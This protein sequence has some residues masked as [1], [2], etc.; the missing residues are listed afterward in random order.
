MDRK[1][2]TYYSKNKKNYSKLSHSL[3]IWFLLLALLPLMTVSL[4]SYNQARTSLMKAASQELEA[5]SNLNVKYIKN[6]FDYRFMDLNSLA[7]T[8]DNANLLMQ[9]S[10]GFN[11]SGQSIAEYVKS[12]DWALIVD[13][14]DNKL[15]DFNRRYDYIYDI[16]LID[17]AGN[18]LF[19]VAH[20]SDFG[21]NLFTGPF[22]ETLFAKTV[23]KSLNTGRSLFSDIERYKPS[24]NTLAGFL[25]APLLD[26]QGET[27]GV[28]T[29]QIRLDKVLS[30][31]QQARSEQVQESLSHYLIGEDKKLRTPIRG[32]VEE[33]LNRVIDSE[34][35]EL[36]DLEHGKDGIEHDDQLESAFIYLGPDDSE[37]IGQHQILRLP[38]VNWA[39]ISEISKNEA[40][41]AAKWLANLTLLV[42][43]V[44]MFVVIILAVLIARRI[45]NPITSLADISMR[46]AEGETDQHVSITAGNEIGKL[47][48]AFNDMLV[49][50]KK[51]ESDLERMSSESSKALAE[52]AEQKFAL[53]QHSIVAITD[54]KGKITFVNSKFTEISG[55]SANELIGQNHRMLNSGRH[56]TD[57]FR[58][59]YQTIAAGKV[60]NSEI[61]NKSKSGDLYWVD[62]TIVPFMG[63]NRK[64]V[65]Y[66]AIRTDITE[67]KKAERELIEAKDQAEEA[68]KAKSEF[69]ASMSHEIRTPMNGVL[70]M[71][72]LLH[73]TELDEVQ[74]HRVQIAQ[75]SAQSLL[76]L[77]ND[78]LDFSK[79]EAGKL[80][81]ELLDF[82]L[83]GMLG[84]LAEAM[85]HQAQ[86]K[87]LELVLDVTGIDISMVVGDAGRLRQIL[88]NL[89]G[90]AIKFTE[91]GEIVIRAELL[92]HK[93]NQYKMN[94]S[95][96]DTGIGIPIEKQ[97]KLFKTFSQVDASTTRKYGGTGLGLTIAKRLCELMGGDIHVRSDAGKGSCFELDILLEKS[98]ESKTV[99][100]EKNLNDFKFLIVDGNASYRKVLCKQFQQWGADV[101]IA[102]NGMHAIEKCQALAEGVDGTYFDIV[103]IEMHMQDMDGIELGKLLREDARYNKTKLVMMTSMSIHGDT[104][105]LADFGF[106]AHFPKPATKSDLLNAL[107]VLN[108]DSNVVLNKEAD[109]MLSQGMFEETE[110]DNNAWTEDTRVLLVE[111]NEVNQLVA[112]ATLD[113]IG[114]TTVVANN[115]IEALEELKGTNSDKRFSLIFMDCQMPKMDG[116]EASRK[117]RAG[118]A[119]NENIP[120]PII[121]LT[122]NA[123]KEDKERCLAAGMDDYLSKPFEQE[124]IEQKLIEWLTLGS[125]D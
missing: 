70:G 19:S 3:V 34:Q 67:R 45:T 18:I 30:L 61:C 50:R 55:Y 43:V 119:G 113:S 89:V 44:T 17:K 46:V 72:A 49:A 57:F 104:H 29:I 56:D 87:G 118:E 77:I 115:G 32:N 38:G 103:F 71:L 59:M 40:L 85:G 26:E 52:L 97:Y 21:T 110:Q 81:L 84:E 2:L 64:P 117:I 98:T 60:W 80:D 120:I 94:C 73:N 20:E 96:S 123:M 39:L 122:A 14:K 65:S 36:L 8:D 58:D 31:F 99:E 53:D 69:L 116:F 105:R 9:L 86:K 90:N 37:V 102:D 82:D 108:D 83:L 66:V 5:L 15:A 13:D 25:S 112:M 101:D 93:N 124:Q 111:D 75:S 51:Y 10:T 125:D 62:T 92:H 35:V 107:K 7:E 68:V 1:K 74:K 42:V 114:V 11:K 41:E 79:V 24:N 47:A 33:V 12:Y 48:D 91:H 76:S 28:L 100:P 95:I 27:I 6:W 4:F 54:V 23:K 22:S 88:T 106:S 109:S 16:F 78:I 63:E 121:A